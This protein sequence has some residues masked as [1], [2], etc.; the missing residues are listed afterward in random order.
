MD[1]APEV[2][3]PREGGGEVAPPPKL[4]LLLVP[5]PLPVAGS[6]I[7]AATFGTTLRRRTGGK[8]AAGLMAAAVVADVPDCDTIGFDPLIIVEKKSSSP[9]SPWRPPLRGAGS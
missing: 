1:A 3:G 6:R 7:E 2:A 9:P 4:G 5:G 8:A